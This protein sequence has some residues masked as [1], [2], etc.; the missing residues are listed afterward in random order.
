MIL[1]ILS[2]IPTSLTGNPNMQYFLQLIRVL[3][4]NRLLKRVN[5]YTLSETI[6]NFFYSIE[7]KRKK[8][9]KLVIFSLWDLLREMGIIIFVTYSLACLWWYYCDLIVKYENE[10]NT[11]IEN[12]NLKNNSKSKQFLKT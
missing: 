11:F 3:K 9:F 10:T 1:D 4:A 6:G 7:N 8:K 12:F 5:P 2:V